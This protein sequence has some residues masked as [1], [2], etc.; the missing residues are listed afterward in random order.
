[1]R[2]W[3]PCRDERG[4]ADMKMITPIKIIAS[5]FCDAVITFCFFY[6]LIDIFPV[7]AIERYYLGTYGIVIYVFMLTFCGFLI[8]LKSTKIIS[9]LCSIGIPSVIGLIIL[10]YL[11][12]VP[13]FIR[14][15]LFN[16]Y[17]E[18]NESIRYGTIYF[19]VFPASCVCVFTCAYCGILIRDR[20]E[21]KKEISDK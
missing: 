7:K 14:I 20:H 2:F 15:P 10:V 1:L 17:R 21:H 12:K 4:L 18:Y 13:D 5:V 19:L 6:V 3:R 8:T 16:Q 9:L 11:T